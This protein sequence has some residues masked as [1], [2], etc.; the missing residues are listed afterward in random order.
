MQGDPDYASREADELALFGAP[1]T[2]EEQS[3]W[4]TPGFQTQ[5]VPLPDP[6]SEIDMFSQSPKT[7][8]GAS[9]S[10]GDKDISNIE[11]VT[12]MA[13]E[14]IHWNAMKAKETVLAHYDPYNQ[15]VEQ[16]N[17]FW[18]MVKDASAVVGEGMKMSFAAWQRLSPSTR[19][20]LI[21]SAATAWAY[22]KGWKETARTTARTT[23]EMY[24]GQ[25]GREVQMESTENIA[26]LQQLGKGAV[27]KTEAEAKAMESALDIRSETVNAL[28][29]SDAFLKM[30]EKN[31]EFFGF[32]IG[33][34]DLS[35]EDAKMVAHRVKE[36]YQGLSKAGIIDPTKEPFMHWASTPANVTEA[37]KQAQAAKIPL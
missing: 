7:G 31:S 6:Q 17:I 1:M 35:E 11:D 25:Q 26:M 34:T 14:Q 3:T 13:S 20:A 5:D 37:I 33:K 4:L 24:A 36:L 16:E 9:G 12:E 27:A 30:A 28:A 10:W 32:S 22:N 8:S 23:A 21:G 15:T 29:S 18:S 19:T 2:D